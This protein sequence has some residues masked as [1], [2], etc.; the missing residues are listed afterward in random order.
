MSDQSINKIKKIYEF[1]LL[2][3]LKIPFEMNYNAFFPLKIK[4]L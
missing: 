4:H 1:K 3:K 2:N